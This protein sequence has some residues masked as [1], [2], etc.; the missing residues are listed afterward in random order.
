MHTCSS[1]GSGRE[2]HRKGKVMNKEEKNKLDDC[3]ST[4]LKTRSPVRR[5]CAP[6]LALLPSTS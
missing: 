1:K 6:H 5:G 4:V 3:S 2:G